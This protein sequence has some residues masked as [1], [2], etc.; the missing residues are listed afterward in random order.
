MTYMVHDAD[1]RWVCPYDA[2]QIAEAHEPADERG[3]YVVDR[4]AR[5]VA[6][7]SLA[8]GSGDLA[9]IERRHAP[10]PLLV[11]DGDA[12]ARRYRRDQAHL[13]VRLARRRGA[14]SRT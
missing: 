9:E 12:F 8:L 2:H 13:A 10:R 11:W 3:G 14:A 7:L 5:E 1:G 4:E 6:H